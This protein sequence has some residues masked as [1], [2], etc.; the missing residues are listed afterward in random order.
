[1]GFFFHNQVRIVW[2]L[3]LVVLLIFFMFVILIIPFCF[4]FTIP[5]FIGVEWVSDVIRNLGVLTLALEIGGLRIRAI[6]RNVSSLSTP[7]T[8]DVTLLEWLARWA[9]CGS[10]R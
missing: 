3:V 10:R 8:R 1:M 6:R 4:L 7:I 5:V 9:C 2:H